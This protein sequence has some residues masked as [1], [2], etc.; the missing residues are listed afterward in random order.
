MP[1][2]H[3]TDISLFKA[4]VYVSMLVYEAEL[5]LIKH[6]G[7]GPLNFTFPTQ[8]SRDTDLHIQ[9]VVMDVIYCEPS[10]VD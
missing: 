9:E 8:S 2:N 5:I 4:C 7:R 6:P 1:C 3:I 10:Q